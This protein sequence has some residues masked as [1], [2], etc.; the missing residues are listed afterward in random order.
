MPVMSLSY[1]DADHIFCSKKRLLKPLL[2]ERVPQ[3]NNPR[4]SYQQL[5]ARFEIDGGLRRGVFFR[6]HAFPGS[7]SSLTFQLECDGVA[8]RT[9]APLYRLELNPRSRHVNQPYGP[10]DVNGLVLPAGVPHEHV[11]KD[12]LTTDG[13]LRSRTDQQAR[14]LPDPPQDFAGALDYVCRRINIVNGSDVPKPEA[15]GDLL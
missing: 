11:F 3:G 1:A 6:I 4:E 10:D 8:G 15:Q 14:L 12:S 7:L 9:R 5:Q 2:W 13:R